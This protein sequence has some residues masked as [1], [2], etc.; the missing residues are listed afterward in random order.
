MIDPAHLEAVGLVATVV[1]IA[2]VLLMN[3][4]RRSCHVVWIGSNALFVLIHLSTTPVVWTMVARDV[5]FL[6]LAFSGFYQWRSISKG[7]PGPPISRD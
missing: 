1:A 6:A 7:P 5:V 4:R 3:A 2:G